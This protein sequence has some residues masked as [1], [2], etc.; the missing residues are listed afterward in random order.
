MLAGEP[1]TAPWTKLSGDDER[2][3]FYAGTRRYRAA[4][5]PKPAQYR[6]NLATG[7]PSL[8]VVLRPT[9]SDPPYELF[10]VTADPSEGEAMTEAGNNIVEPVPM[11]QPIAETGRGLRRRA[12]C[13][14]SVLQAQARPRR[15]GGA[16]AA[17]AG[18][19][20][21]NER[22]GFPQALV[23]PQTRGRRRKKRSLRARRRPTSRRKQPT[24]PRAG[25]DRSA[26]RSREP[27]AGRID[28]RAVRHQGV[29]ARGR[30]GRTHPCGPS[31][32]VDSRSRDPRL[33]RVL[34]RTPGTSP[35]RM[36]CR[37]SVR[38]KRPRRSAA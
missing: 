24:R 12:P 36:R 8:W 28:H 30:A 27:A 17:R 2:A 38:W 1:D 23:A 20:R 9:E 14:A 13:R 16:R 11:P 25:Q 26:V 31:T 18:R 22:R 7:S 32:R 10:A 19:I 15:S 35:T 33:R 21:A 5:P 4:S 37:A 34:R 6:D 29:P 3:S